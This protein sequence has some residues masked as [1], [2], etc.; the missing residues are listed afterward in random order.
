MTRLLLSMEVERGV[1][2]PAVVKSPPFCSLGCF[3]QQ[4]GEWEPQAFF[5]ILFMTY[6]PAHLIRLMASI[7]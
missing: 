1:C 3:G 2:S 7:H 6:L 4:V 5:V